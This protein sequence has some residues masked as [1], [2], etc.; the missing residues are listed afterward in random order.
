MIY[1]CINL[2]VNLLKQ[3]IP[4]N[5]G[6]CDIEPLVIAIWCGVGKPN[7]L[8]AFLHP[9]VAELKEVMQN[10]LSINGN[11]ITIKVRCFICDTPARALLKGSFFHMNILQFIH[12]FVNVT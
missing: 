12:Y 4:K 9:F 7:E 6:V 8:N 10:G 1:E 3:S 11:R 5:S 2:S